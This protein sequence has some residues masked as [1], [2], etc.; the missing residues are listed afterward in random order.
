MDLN[1]LNHL[2]NDLVKELGNVLISTD[3]WNINCAEPIV[4]YN[5]QPVA[6]TLFNQ[7]TEYIIEALTVG[8]Y[9]KL[10]KYY[11][12]SLQGDKMVIIVPLVD[13]IWEMLIDTQKARLG[14]ILNSTVPNLIDRFN[15]LAK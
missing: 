12:L 2:L 10:E 15:A 8:E 3:V 7:I 1:K 11:I 14:V 6:C 4:G 9:P 5:S 13:C